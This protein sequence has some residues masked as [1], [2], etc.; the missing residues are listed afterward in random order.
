MTAIRKLIHEPPSPPTISEIVASVKRPRSLIDVES[1][2]ASMREQHN[3]L[4]SQLSLM[5][6]NIDDRNRRELA[7]VI[8]QTRQAKAS[9]EDQ[10]AEA[11][12]QHS[13]ER[14]KYIR[15]VEKALQKRRSEALEGIAR[16]WDEM[17]AGWALLDEIRSELAKAD[18][19]FHI[20]PAAVGQLR[21][22]V[23]PLVERTLKGSV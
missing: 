16:G 1:R 10:I 6:Q 20:R 5:Q 8:K 9:L 18:M 11:R 15:A 3:E 21:R 12:K 4:S 13:A 2:L 19:H 7:P 22:L 23:G 17:T 14:A